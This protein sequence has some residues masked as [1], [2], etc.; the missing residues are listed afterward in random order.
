[1]ENVKLMPILSQK[2]ANLYGDVESVKCCNYVCFCL[3]VP[4]QQQAGPSCGVSALNMANESVKDRS[5]RREGEELDV[6]KECVRDCSIEKFEPGLSALRTSLKLG[7]SSDGELFC[8]YN[9][10]LVGQ[11][12]LGLH[13]NVLTN[14]DVSVLIKEILVGYPVLVPYDRSLSD[15]RPGQFQGGKAHWCIVAGLIIPTPGDRDLESSELTNPIDFPNV[16]STLSLVTDREA[17]KEKYREEISRIDETTI[18][19]C[20]HS[21]S[22]SPFLCTFKELRDSNQQLECSKSKFYMAPESLS[23]LKGKLLIVNH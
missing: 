10:S 15:H 1:M 18:L 23:H 12:A 20:V 16:V 11:L 19:V 21:M 8:A 14:W 6:C 17:F 7:V 22:K 5:V 13:T 4:W 2:L 9:F 3:P